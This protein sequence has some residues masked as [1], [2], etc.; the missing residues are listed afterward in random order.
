M[1]NIEELKEEIIRLKDENLELKRRLELVEERLSYYEEETDI[2]A[3]DIYHTLSEAEMD[4][5]IGGILDE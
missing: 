5:L 3:D 1:K 2:D 4:E